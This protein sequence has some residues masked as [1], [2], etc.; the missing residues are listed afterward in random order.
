MKEGAERYAGRYA[1]LYAGA[2]YEANVEITDGEGTIILGGGQR[3]PVYYAGNGVFQHKLIDENYAF[4]ESA[5]GK[6]Q[7]MGMEKQER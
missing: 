1:G 7:F 6:I 3:M 5:R 4:T 2:D